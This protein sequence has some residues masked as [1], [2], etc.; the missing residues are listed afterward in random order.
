ME[1]NL[2]TTDHLTIDGVTKYYEDKEVRENLEALGLYVDED[3]D[4]CQTED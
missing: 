1:Y 2:D 3:G 4:V